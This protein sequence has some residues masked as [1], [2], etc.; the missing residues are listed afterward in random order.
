[1][2]PHAVFIVSTVYNPIPSDISAYS[3]V[4]NLIN[5]INS[6]ILEGRLTYGYDIADTYAAFENA[7][8]EG[9][10][11]T[12]FNLDPAKGPLNVDIHPNATG[13]AIIA[14]LHLDAIN[15]L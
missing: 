7:E 9:V 12:N 1:M 13:H 10:S 3:T 15:G 8:L 5:S 11:V 4:N 14:Q 6:V 2:A